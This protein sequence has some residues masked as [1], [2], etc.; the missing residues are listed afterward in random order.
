MKMRII[1]S[2][3]GTAGHIT[4]AIAIADKLKE[5]DEGCEI[6]FV[7]SRN[8][9]E[10]KL[11]PRAGYPI[12]QLDVKGIKRKLSLDNFKA[13][14]QTVKAVK[15]SKE[16]IRDF[17]PDAVLGTGGYVCYPILK[18]AADMGVYTALHE[19]NAIPGLAVRMLKKRADKIFV[20]FEECARTL[21]VGEKALVT[22]NPVKNASQ[23]LSREQAREKLGMNGRYRYL[24]ISFGGSLGAKT[25]NACALEVMDKLSTRR[26][27]ILHI[28]AYGKNDASEF[29]EEFK[30]RGYDKYKNI[31]VNEYIYDM[32]IYMRA[33]DAVM[34]RS[35]AMTL[36]ELASSGIASVLIP[37]PNVTANHQYKNAIAFENVGAAFVVDEKKGSAPE[38]ALGYVSAI[39]SDK[40]LRQNMSR[41]ALELAHPNASETIASEILRGVKQK[42][43]ATNDLN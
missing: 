27:D 25:V 15:R 38:Q 22:G 28:H 10:N 34:C 18:A 24:L 37:S 42:R 12:W 13:V 14:W 20:S 40:E 33:A 19:S 6:V 7:G 32:P 26:A 29:F 31:V 17:K 1:V 11:V 9:M 36:A 30:R 35:G 2:G 23:E 5:L 43:E 39:I 16:L 41:R 8:G 3:G 21:N 4:P